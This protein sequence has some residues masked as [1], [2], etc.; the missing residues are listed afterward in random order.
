MPDRAEQLLAVLLLEALVGYPQALHQRVPHPVVWAGKL[1]SALDHRWNGAGQRCSSSQRKLGSPTVAHNQD[2][3][4]PSLLCDNEKRTR[5][6]G[7]ALAALLVLLGAFFGLALQ[8]LL[9]GWTGAALII[10]I[11]T[12]GLAQKSLHDH[13]L[14][15]ARPLSAGRLEDARRALSMIVGRDTQGLDDQS[16]AAAG[17]ESLAES[18]CDGVVA[19]AFWFLVAGLPGLFAFKAISTADSLI[20]HKDERHRH[21]GWASARLD[22]VLNF[23]PARISG[24]LICLA[25]FRLRNPHPGEGRDPAMPPEPAPGLRRGTCAALRIMLRDARK[26]LSPNAGWPEAAMAGALGVRLGGGAFYDGEWIGRAELG[27]GSPPAPPDL[28][29]ALILYRRALLL[30]WLTAGG[31]AWAL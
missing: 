3:K 18:F 13:V 20:G 28:Q 25:A 8:H 30:L 14:A 11:A 29:R 23:I 27:D 10:L 24:L 7:I 12:T 21:F 19:P 1:I 31:L 6:T 26:H 16:V 2:L 4:D 17:T 15:V 22:D 9:T 5:L